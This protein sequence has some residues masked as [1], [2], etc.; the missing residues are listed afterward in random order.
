[1]RNVFSPSDDSIRI[2]S[3]SKKTA[4]AP[5]ID[6]R[7]RTDVTRLYFKPTI[8]ENEKDP[9]STIRGKLIYERKGRNDSAFPLDDVPEKISKNSIKKGDTLELELHASEVRRLYQ[10]LHDLYALSGEMEGIPFGVKTYVPLDSASRPVLYLL[11]S[12]PSATRKIASGETNVIVKELLKL[13]TQGTSPEEIASAFSDLGQ[14]NLRSL[15]ESVNLE[16][17]R[18]VAKRIEDNLDNDNEDFWQTD[19][20]GS[21]Q[22]ILGHL[23]AAPCTL[24]QSKAYV[25]GKSIDNHCGNI[26]DFLYQ[27]DLTGNV[28]IIEIKTP[29]TKILGRKYRNVCYELTGEISGAVNQVLGYR[30][31]LMNNI[32][33]L[34]RESEKSFEALHPRCILI[35]GRIDELSDPKALS[36]FENFRQSLNGVFIVTYDELLQRIKDL[37]SLLTV[38]GP[39]SEPDEWG[40]RRVDEDSSSYEDAPF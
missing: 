34:Q 12:D 39:Q 6:L 32:A 15:S 38:P 19:V 36:T 17:L 27:N 7:D 13:L 26:A 25:G 4:S 23:F 11:R 3:T 9:A 16:L 24:F 10:G 21:Q 28:A 5:D 8:V 14:G 30:Q 40:L 22:W 20:F 2:E 35:A 33:S 37:I 18:R 31:S 1:M 29:Q